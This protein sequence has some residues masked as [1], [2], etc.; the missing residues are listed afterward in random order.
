MQN[1]LYLLCFL[2][3]G[4]LISAKQLIVTVLFAIRRGK[5]YTIYYICCDIC[6]LDGGMDRD[7]LLSV[8]RLSSV[9]HG[10]MWTHGPMSPWV[11]GLHAGV[12]RKRTKTKM[13]TSI[14]TKTNTILQMSYQT[15]TN[16]KPTTNT[17]PKNH[18][19][20]STKT[21]QEANPL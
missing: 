21:H 6:N 10:P 13:H 2:Q 4:E 19:P 12:V 9:C 18:H 14:K 3:F 17:P 1:S 20:E 16:E 15:K 5:E 11:H 8:C 7:K